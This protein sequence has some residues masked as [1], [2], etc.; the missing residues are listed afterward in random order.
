MDVVEQTRVWVIIIL[1]Q[2]FL[3]QPI[4]S[5]PITWWCSV[6]YFIQKC[7]RSISFEPYYLIMLNCLLTSLSF[8]LTLLLKGQKIIVIS[9]G[10]LFSSFFFHVDVVEQI[11]W[12]V[13]IILHQFLNQTINSYPITCWSSVFYFIQKCI[14]SIPFEPY[15]LIMP[16]A[17]SFP[18]FFFDFV[19]KMKT[20]IVI[21]VSNLFSSF[22]FHVDVVEQI[23]WW[24][25]I[26]LH[27]F[28][29]NQT[30]NSYTITCWYSVFDSLIYFLLSYRSW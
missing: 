16:I 22:F 21:S 26:I 24:V 29:L 19:A 27:Q 4:N 1:H 15:Y 28:L 14:R 6:F 18:F 23:S 12:W 10:N 17:C 20:I 3:N 8:S 25:I 13:I 7:I 30:V 11:S 5:Y 9:V 2:L